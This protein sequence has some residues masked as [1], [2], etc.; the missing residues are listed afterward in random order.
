MACV[1]WLRP[2][3]LRRT[4]RIRSARTHGAQRGAFDDLLMAYMGVHV[5]RVGPGASSQPRRPKKKRD[6]WQ[7]H[8]DVVGY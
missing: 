4:C 7:P 3:R 8:D 2:G 5:S 6:R 1:T